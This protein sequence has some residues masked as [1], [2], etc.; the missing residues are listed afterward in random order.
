MLAS[1]F[2]LLQ[3]IVHTGKH[4]VAFVISVAVQEGRNDWRSWLSTDAN[5]LGLS[6][7]VPSV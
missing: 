2:S 3:Y 1:I 7:T 4:V 6:V 5:L